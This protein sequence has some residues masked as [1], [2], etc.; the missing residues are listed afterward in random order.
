MGKNADNQILALK[1]SLLIQSV[2][3]LRRVINQIIEEYGTIDQINCELS[4]DVK[5]NRM[6]RFMHK[7]DQKRIMEN[8]K[9]YI[10]LLKKNSIDLTP[11][12]I[13]KYEL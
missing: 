3:E 2:F 7:L 9:R 12:N 1:N 13:L 8:N 5:V 10:L 6:Q 11:M 4:V